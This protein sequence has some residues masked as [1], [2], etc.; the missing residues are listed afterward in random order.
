MQP[1]RHAPTTG[2][3]PRRGRPV[4]AWVLPLALACVS[5]AAQQAAPPGGIYTCV[6]DRGRKLTSDRPIAECSARE[7]R[8]LNRDGSLRAIHPPTLTAEERAAKEARERQEAERRA[9]AA[10]AVRRDRNLIARFPD[11]ASHE[12]AREAALEPVRAA[13]RS[14]ALRMSALEAE[15]KPMLDEA[16]FYLGR[17]VPVSLKAQ[18]DANEAAMVAQRI[19]MQTLE[20]ELDRINRVYDVELARLRQLWAGAAPGSLGPVAAASAADAPRP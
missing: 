1:P 3:T 19:A 10:D 13:M 15:R 17:A 16:E 11:E 18:L 9:A 2:R 6:D 5:A 12:R 4:R 20:T 8:V 7:Q 14:S